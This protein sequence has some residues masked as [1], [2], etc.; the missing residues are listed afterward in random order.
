MTRS[1]GWSGL[2]RFGSPPRL[3]HRVAHRGEVD[4]ARHA[5]EVL[6]QHAARCGTRSPSRPG[7][8]RPSCASASMSPRF[9]NASSSFRSRF[10]RRIFRLNGSRST[11]AARERSERIEAKD[12]VLP[13][14]DVSVAR[15]PKEF[16]C[17]MGRLSLCARSH[18]TT[19]ARD[20]GATGAPPSGHVRLP[21]SKQPCGA[22][23]NW[24]SSIRGRWPQPLAALA[25]TVARRQ[26]R[27]PA[28]PSRT[29][30]AGAARRGF[31]PL[32]H[33]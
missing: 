4:D 8:S 18:G 32:P 20:H 6:E 7:A 1:T 16:G 23:E 24:A 14:R 22:C 11:D 29:T 15:L 21:Q 28:L 30:T 10:S 12:G 31:A 3:A 25:A 13:P 19:G 33:R 17:V 27:T 2:I 9:T 5:G 26:A